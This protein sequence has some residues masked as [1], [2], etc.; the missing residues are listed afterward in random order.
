MPK[1][2]IDR[3]TLLR[4][5]LS[6]FKEKGYSAASMSDIAAANGLLKGSIYHYVEG[7]EAL[8]KEVLIALKDHYINKV[9]SKAYDESLTPIARL[10]ELAGRAEEIFMHEEGGDF[11]VNIG[12]ETSK[13]NPAFAAIISSFFKEWM[14]TLQHLYAFVM[15]G[16]EAKAK[17]ETTVAEIEGAVIL[18]RLLN[19]PNY[20]HRTN[21]NLL[22]EYEELYKNLNDELEVPY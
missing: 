17:A 14:R 11:F 18:M 2:K 8:M 4:N 16:D 15:N 21:E 6:V 12:L 7:K 19:D 13:S 5:S 3:K 10:T 1:A 9:F 20:L 22:K